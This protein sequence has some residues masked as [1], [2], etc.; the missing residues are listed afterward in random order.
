MKKRTQFSL[1]EEVDIVRHPEDKMHAVVARELG[2]ARSTTAL[3]LKDKDKVM[4]CED[5]SQLAPSRKQPRLGDFQL[6]D[7][8]VLT[9]FKD[10]R[11]Q[12]VPLPGPLIQEKAREFAAILIVTDFEAYS[13][14]HHRFRQQNAITWRTVSRKK[15]AADEAA[16]ST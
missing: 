14:W 13:G 12:N 9:W 1:S 7:P 2:V 6:I 10:V 3:I 4:K 15:K 8:A 16:A 11:A 5:Q